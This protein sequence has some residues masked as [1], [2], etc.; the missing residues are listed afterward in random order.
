MRYLPHF[1]EDGQTPRNL[2]WIFCYMLFPECEQDA[3]RAATVLDD[4]KKV[5]KAGLQSDY[6]TVG[7]LV[8]KEMTSR[9]TEVRV[10]GQIFYQMLLN[11]SARRTAEYRK[12]NYAVV[13]WL[14]QK[15]NTEGQRPKIS[16]D[17]MR[18][19]FKQYR[20]SLHLWALYEF[21]ERGEKEIVFKDI[22]VF[23]KF[24]LGSEALRRIAVGQ[25]IQVPAPAG[26]SKDWDPWCPHSVYSKILDSGVF[27][28]ELPG[29]NPDFSAI[30]RGYKNKP[31]DS[32]N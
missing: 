1:E 4:E 13:E 24:K 19:K 11:Q 3:I 28:I 16:G 25:G 23:H 32:S 10:S 15:R 31:F 8:V 9:V 17:R 14:S 29:E 12:A 26:S 27:D 21:L 30:L 18:G 22:A 2:D 5:I 20:S 7:R 6:G